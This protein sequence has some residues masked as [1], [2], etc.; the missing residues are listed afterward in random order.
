MAEAMA[1]AENG[2]ARRERLGKKQQG[3]ETGQDPG[4]PVQP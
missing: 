3:M 2:N 4:G 1:A